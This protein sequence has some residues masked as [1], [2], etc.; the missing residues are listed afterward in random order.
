[1]L[2]RVH[3]HFKTPFLSIILFSTIAILNLIPSHF[4]QEGFLRLGTLY[5]F[6]SLLSFMFA[7]AAIIGIRIKYPHWHRPF[8]LKANITIKN[9]EMPLTAVLGLL[10]TLVTWV[11][12][13]F[14][15]PYS[16]WFGLLWIAVGV[17]IY[18]IFRRYN[19][20]PLGGTVKKSLYIRVRDDRVIK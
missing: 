1:M 10:G 9:R 15:Q 18:I 17:V 13:V 3:K 12:L 8:K 16:R 14:T 7:H 4:A 6:G 19:K 2:S 20:L 11:V 5:A